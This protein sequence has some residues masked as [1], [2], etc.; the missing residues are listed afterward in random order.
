MYMEINGWRL[1]NAF[2]P[3]SLD[4]RTEEAVVIVHFPLFI[5]LITA[6]NLVF[7]LTGGQA[8]KPER[9]SRWEGFPARWEC[10]PMNERHDQVSEPPLLYGMI[11]SPAARG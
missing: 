1:R 2:K 4:E 9:K 11:D 5:R 10:V 6:Y 8:H 7:P 3:D